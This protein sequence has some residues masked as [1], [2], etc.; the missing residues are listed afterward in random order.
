MN[1]WVTCTSS[2]KSQHCT[3]IWHPMHWEKS[4][5]TWCCMC[6]I[7]MYWGDDPRTPDF[8]MVVLYIILQAKELVALIK[9]F[10]FSTF[11]HSRWLT[12]ANHPVHV[13]PL[14]TELTRCMNSKCRFPLRSHHCTDPTIHQ[15][16]PTCTG[17]LGA[18]FAQY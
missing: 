18:F 14:N 3:S 10:H 6:N 15:K 7:Q 12:N 2:C 1:R 17:T 5:S 11:L 8:C 4:P 16:I 13:S 9:I